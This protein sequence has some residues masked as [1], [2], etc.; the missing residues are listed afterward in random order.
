MIL[1]ILLG[2]A[3]FL[4]A[5]AVGRFFL[6]EELSGMLKVTAW[7]LPITAIGSISHNLLYH[8]LRQH[9][10]NLCIFLGFV[11]A[12]P[13]TLYLGCHGFGAWA[14]VWPMLIASCV[15]TCAVICWVRWLPSWEFS[16]DALW[17]LFRFGSNLLAAALLGT[18]FDN[19]YNVIIGKWCS[20]VKLGYFDRA[21]Q[22]AAIWPQSIQWTIG[23]VLF[24]AFAKIQDETQRLRNAFGASLQVS[25]FII[26][27]PSL[28][29][30]ALAHPFIELVLS[31]KWLPIVVYFQ[32]LTMNFILFPLLNINYQVLNARG[33]SGTYL[34]LETINKL[35]TV[36]NILCTV[37]F[38]L[39]WMVLGMVLVSVISLLINTRYT[40]REIDYPLS[41]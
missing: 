28:L 17:K 33:K 27:F 4:A 40:K 24:P 26:V 21:K 3:I 13:F 8:Q 30:A 9:I 14:L 29:L 32:I 2:C 19:I 20:I 31:E 34:Y 5:P 38:D 41:L 23:S 12:I 25:V 11:A 39:V 6:Q 18:L 10:S 22:Y 15:T 1:S 35:L 16:L 37:W 36:L 7:I